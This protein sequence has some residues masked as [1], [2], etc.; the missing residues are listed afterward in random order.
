MAVQ[1]GK[2]ITE[3]LAKLPQE[4]PDRKFIDGLKCQ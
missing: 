2:F 3:Q 1:L 4:Q